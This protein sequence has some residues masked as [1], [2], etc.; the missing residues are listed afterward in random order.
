MALHRLKCLF[1]ELLVN[2]YESIVTEKG[3][4]FGRKQVNTFKTSFKWNSISF[5]QLCF[6]QWVFR[7]YA[8][9]YLFFFFIE[10]VCTLCVWK[11]N[12]FWYASRENVGINL[13]ILNIQMRSVDSPTYD[14]CTHT[15]GLFTIY[16]HVYLSV[17]INNEICCYLSSIGSSTSIRIIFPRKRRWLEMSSPSSWSITPDNCRS[18]GH[19][20][21]PDRFGFPPFR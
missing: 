1:V 16:T 19:V 6:W 4:F 2:N 5:L 18:A 7:N 3:V 12:H 15:L 11:D 17:D 14:T 20:T 9:G 13:L 21:R 8:V 10:I